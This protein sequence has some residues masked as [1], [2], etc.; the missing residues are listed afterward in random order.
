MAAAGTDRTRRRLLAG[1]AATVAAPLLARSARAAGAV[2]ELYVRTPG[3]AYDQQRRKTLYEPFE[4][5]T[6]VRVVPVASSVSKL[7]TLART[8]R[9]GLDV[10]ETGDD[11]LYLLEDMKALEP[12]DY[13]A[14]RRTRPDDIDPRMRRSHHVGSTV[15][16]DVLGYSTRAFS[17]DTAPR[18]WAAFW[19]VQGHAGARSLA[20]MASGSPNLEFALLADGVDP[21]SLYPLDLDRAFRS[22]SRVRPAI[23]KFW[24]SGAMATQMLV[25]GEVVLSSIWS[26]RANA[27]RAAGAAVGI[28]WEQ[29][30]VNMT[31]AGIAR[32]A[33]NR[34]AALAYLDYSLS[35]AVQARI[36]RESGDIPVNRQAHHAIDK[37]QLDAD[38]V[39]WTQSRGILKDS[40]WWADNR[41]QVSARW[42]RWVLG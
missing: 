4:R 12:I 21:G 9:A 18:G 33:R 42:A 14:F 38:G 41:Q 34:E 30:L 24:S 22:L 23:T 16:A 31:A 25:D 28:G 3:G 8:G 6:G 1:A 2:R 13:G 37:A 11:I 10:I 39:P 32:N 27:A 15:Y 17:A 40:R 35:P 5:D 36:V 7:V 29:N 20:D 26:S 19:D